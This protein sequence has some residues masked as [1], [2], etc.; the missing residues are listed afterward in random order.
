MIT[1]IHSNTLLGYKSFKA[2][3]N[4]SHLAY[5]FK[6]TMKNCKKACWA[7]EFSLHS[8]SQRE[9]IVWY[10]ISKHKCQ[11]LYDWM[12]WART[13]PQPMLLGASHYRHIFVELAAMAPF[14][15]TSTI[16]YSVV[17]VVVAARKSQKF[18]RTRWQTHMS[19][20]HIG[21]KCP[22]A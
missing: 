5:I 4:N 13:P 11:R 17:V 14:F 15:Y 8:N 12:V 1:W 2:N 9:E 7:F 20:C 22:G 16:Y 3:E 18:Q 6:A 19:P 10:V 21:Q